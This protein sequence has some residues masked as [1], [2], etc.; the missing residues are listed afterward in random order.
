MVLAIRGEPALAG[1]RDCSDFSNQKQAQ[2][3]FVKK[4]G[5]SKDP[6][7]LDGDRDG[8]ACEAL[9]CPCSQ[10]T[11][12]G[13]GSTG[14]GTKPKK[15]VVR[16]VVDGDTIKVRHR[17]REK[18]VR[19]IGIDTPEV[20]GKRECGGRQ[21]SRSLKRM[22]DPGERIKLIPDRTQAR[23]DRYGRL[24]RY[25]EDGGRD[26]GKRQIARGWARVYVFERRFER[27]N[28]YRRSQK[29]A[30]RADRG[31][32]SKCNGRF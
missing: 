30:K 18:S 5:P 23:R 1:D 7:R 25:V 10:A 16:S 26:V 8:V 21:A 24:L 9:P 19:L 11:G 20:Y 2:E 13:G 31:A 12:G 32:W 29:R 22:L 27:V 14:S 4:G 6:H 15:T 17:G 28:K 3:F